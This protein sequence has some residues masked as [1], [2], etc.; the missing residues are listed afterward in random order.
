LCAAEE[1]A[2]DRPY[3]AISPDRRTL[4]GD[5]TLSLAQ[6]SVAS[7]GGAEFM[8]RLPGAMVEEESL[9]VT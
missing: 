8:A 1:L 6:S 9:W 3:N 4:G 7:L 5:V 2:D